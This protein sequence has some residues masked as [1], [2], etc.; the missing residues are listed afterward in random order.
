MVANF[1][2]KHVLQ[3]GRRKRREKHEMPRGEDLV[4]LGTLPP[5]SP[6]AGLGEDTVRK[7]RDKGAGSNGSL[8]TSASGGVAASTRGQVGVFDERE[9]SRWNRELQFEHVKGMAPQEALVPKDATAP[10]PSHAEQVI[11]AAERAEFQLVSSLDE[12]QR[13]DS[14]VEVSGTSNNH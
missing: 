6:Q 3:R 2:S 10:S 8:S 9:Q 4:T 13:Q 12:L 11:K 7:S 14:M 5:T 1:V